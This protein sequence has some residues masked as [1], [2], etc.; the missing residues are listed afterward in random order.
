MDKQE[1]AGGGSGHF[2]AFSAGF[3]GGQRARSADLSSVSGC[4][5]NLSAALDQVLHV[6]LQ[7]VQMLLDAVEMLN[8]FVR[9]QTACVPLVLG[10]SDLFHRLVK[11]ASAEKTTK[12]KE[13]WYALV[14][15]IYSQ[16]NCPKLIF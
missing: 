12:K 13:F 4:G 3:W 15:L 16:T 11:V 14:S 2:T 1:G 9:P 10:R 6:L 5:P 8:G 7:H